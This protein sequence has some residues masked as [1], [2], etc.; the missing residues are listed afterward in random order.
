MPKGL[1]GGSSPQIEVGGER[2]AEWREG[3]K[4]G[5]RRRKIVTDFLRTNNMQPNTIEYRYKAVRTQK[6]SW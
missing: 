6:K 4:K 1:R 3:G 5:G 2:E